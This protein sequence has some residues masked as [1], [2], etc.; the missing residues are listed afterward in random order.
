MVVDM[1][2]V[3]KTR[4]GFILKEGDTKE[5]DLICGRPSLPIVNGR[6]QKRDFKIHFCKS[7]L[8]GHKQ[9]RPFYTASGK[10]YTLVS[11]KQFNKRTH[12]NTGCANASWRKA[13]IVKKKPQVKRKDKFAGFHYTKPNERQAYA[14]ARFI[15]SLM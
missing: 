2:K 3:L 12:C 1:S 9:L 8:C 6:E 15:V 4:N 7:K 14:Y 11:S 5:S 13:P 10:G